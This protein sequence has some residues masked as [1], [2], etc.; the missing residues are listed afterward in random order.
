MILSVPA[1]SSPSI[2][3]QRRKAARPQELLA[4]GL[5]LFVRKGLAA[6]RIEDVARE[7]GV[8]KGTLY[9]Y[10]ASKDELFKAV[11]H[12]YVTQVI[13][14]SGDVADVFE[15]T[16]AEL[17]RQLSKTWWTRVGSSDAAGLIA[18]IMREA[19]SFPDLAQLYVNEVLMPTHALLRRIVER[20]IARGEFRSLD[21]TSV[22]HGLVAPMQF[23]ILYSRCASVCTVNPVPLEPELFLNTQIELLLHG[24]SVPHPALEKSA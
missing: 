12:H 20:G 5:S 17:L 2:P 24:L 9:L 7:A 1:T 22:V 16:T 11:V 10:Y 4:A 6:T 18:L 21:I 19:S 23:L 8:S 14:D 13:A 15:G 3:R